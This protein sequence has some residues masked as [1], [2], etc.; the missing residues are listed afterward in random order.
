MIIDKYAQNFGLKG[1]DTCALGYLHFPDVRVNPNVIL[2]LI[3]NKVCLNGC[4]QGFGATDDRIC[5]P[6][7]DR[8]LE[9]YIENTQVMKKKNYDGFIYTLFYSLCVALGL[10]ILWM[11][12]VFTIPKYIPVISAVGAIASLTAIAIAT[13]LST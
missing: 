9:D 12:L 10:A 2:H 11:V 1:Y 8:L 4:P 6:D 13:A 5:L 7:D 3:Q